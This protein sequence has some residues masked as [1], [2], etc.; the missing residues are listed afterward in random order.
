MSR[1]NKG[2]KIDKWSVAV[3]RGGGQKIVA[4]KLG[5][6]ESELNRKQNGKK[7]EKSGS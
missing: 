7:A 5:I 6:S 1:K 2:N 4:L 3:A